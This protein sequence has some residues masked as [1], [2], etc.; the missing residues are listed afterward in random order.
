MRR[1]ALVPCALAAAFA[2]A[3]CTGVPDGVAPVTGFDA[4]RYVGTW[5]SIARLDH[6]FE[7]GLTNVSARYALR[8]DGT[9]EVVNVGFRRDRCEW[10]RI[11]GSARFVGAPDVGSLGVTFQWPFTGGYHV[12]ALD[13]DG[14]RWAMVSGPNRDY[15]WILAREPTLAPEIRERLVAQ[16]RAAAFPVD[17]LQAVDQSPPVCADGRPGPPPPA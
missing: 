12:F 2:L 16:A 4:Q 17:E 7:R 11:E 5:Y 13:R 14:Y 6:P 15:L 10:E 1:L 8:P 9:V 3:A